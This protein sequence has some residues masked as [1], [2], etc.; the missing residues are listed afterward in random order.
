MNFQRQ[1]ALATRGYRG[2]FGEKYYINE[3]I[4]LDE[5]GLIVDFIDT[6][7]VKSIESISVDVVVESVG[8]EVNSIEIEGAQ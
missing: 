6:I 7:Q 2:D 4:S 3:E 1:L 8:V 5:G